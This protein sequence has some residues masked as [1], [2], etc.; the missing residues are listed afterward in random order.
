M[1]RRFRR[2]SLWL[3]VFTSGA[4][5]ALLALGVWQLQRLAWKES[6]IAERQDR[7]T[8]PAV[9]LAEALAEPEALTFR[10]LAL[11][12]QWRASQDLRLVSR[13]HKGQVGFHLITPLVLDD[14]RAV[15]VDRGWL[16]AGLDTPDGLAAAGVEGPAEIAGHLR[17]G[18]W[19]GSLGFQP[20]NDPAANTWLWFDLPAMAEALELEAPVTV[21]Y[22][23]AAP[24]PGFD[25]AA[26]QPLATVPSVN[27][28][29]DHLGYAVTWFSLAVAL[30]VIF[31]LYHLRRE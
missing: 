25:P 13:T 14:G 27:L 17:Q 5:V 7:L 15:L 18:G 6:L 30:A 19:Q 31:L 2:P 3:S 23:Q 9:T 21:F 11:R 29:N 10:K 1:G 26:G 20:V 28:K 8:A 22:L 16:S 4:L 24:L 12:G